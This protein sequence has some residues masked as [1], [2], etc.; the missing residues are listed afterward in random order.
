[1]YVSTHLYNMYEA[2]PPSRPLRQRDFSLFTKIRK[3]N[4]HSS[5]F[6][7]HS[8]FNN[9]VSTIFHSSLFT[10][11]K[12]NSHSSFFIF[13]SSFFILHFSFYILHLRRAPVSGALPPDI[14]PVFYH[15]PWQIST[16]RQITHIFRKNIPKSFGSSE[17]SSTFALA[18]RK[19]VLLKQ[20]N[21]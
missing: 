17:K 9:C 21:C 7:L 13:H 4:S 20:I 3:C 8:S 19:T 18:F 1:M 14:L 10:K 5:F 16:K 6:I 11:R 2:S 12:C 15:I